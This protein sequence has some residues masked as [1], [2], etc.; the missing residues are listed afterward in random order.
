VNTRIS[1]T[2]A[3]NRYT[4]MAFCDNLFNTLGYDGAVGIPVSAAG[5][6]QVIDR[7]ASFTAPRTFGVELQYRW[8]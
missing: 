7:L 8:R 6:N 5:A 3:S 1:F 2:D 4:V